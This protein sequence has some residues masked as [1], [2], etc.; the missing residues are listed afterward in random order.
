MPDVTVS[1]FGVFRFSESVRFSGTLA[2]AVSGPAFPGGR[3]S[4]AVAVYEPGTGSR[5]AFYSSD[6]GGCPLVSASF[7]LLE[8]GCGAFSVAFNERPDALCIRRGDRVEIHPMGSARPWF[9]GRVLDVPAVDTGGGAFTYK[10]HG[11]FAD[12]EAILVDRAYAGAAIE[13]MVADLAAA[14]LPADVL[15]PTDR[16]MPL[17]YRVDS[18]AG[19]RFDR[20]TLKEALGKLAEL[21]GDYLYGV[22]EDRELF[23]A[24][25]QGRPVLGWANRACHWVGHTLSDFSLAEKNEV[26]NRLYVKI[27]SVNGD[28]GNFTD[29][30]VEDADSIAFFGVREAV[31]SAPQIRNE[32]DARTWAGYELAGRA[33]PS[34]AGKAKNLDLSGWVASRDDMIRAGEHLRISMPRNG[35][36]APFH[37]PVNGRFRWEGL[38]S[39]R[40]YG[41]HLLMF[42]FS[43][44]RPGPLG[45]VEILAR[46]FGNPGPLG[47]SLSPD[48]PGIAPVYQGGISGQGVG[49]WFAWAACDFSTPCPA[50]YGTGLVAV[51]SVPE[52]GLSDPDNGYEVLFSTRGGPYSGGYLETGDSGETW[53]EDTGRGILFRAYLTHADEFALSVKR[54]AYTADAAGGIRADVDLG[55]VDRP[56]ENRILEMLRA[57]KAEEMLQ[58]SNLKDLA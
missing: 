18:A 45:R 57:I 43:P 9:S 38:G 15:Y 21:A 2:Y 12:L 31:V 54:V 8:S 56:L 5:K 39:S 50:R 46:K 10:G 17:G 37:E 20:V 53:V 24:P 11:H 40:V 19:I 32:A 55:E 7:E 23:F 4:L 30:Y 42:R 47:V 1:Q 33:W 13:E 34:I 49:N 3:L 6:A 26:A 29:F 25:R 44:R 41:G 16:L 14:Y 36:A 51:I 58:Q 22:N 28:K 48:S 52:P 35:L 27:G